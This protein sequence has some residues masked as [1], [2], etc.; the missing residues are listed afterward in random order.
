MDSDR[1]NETALLQLAR[2]V[3]REN[4]DA[5]DEHERWAVFRAAIDGGCSPSEILAAVTV[6][7]DVVGVAT[8]VILEMLERVPPGEM[9]AWT[10]VIP[11]GDARDLLE[12]RAAEVVVLRQVL[13][14][15]GR[16]VQDVSTWSDWL[17]RRVAV[18]CTDQAVLQVLTT[19]GRTKRVRGQAGE[20][21]RQCRRV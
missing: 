15:P 17:Q 9:A 21:L 20:R 16:G 3:G 8:S 10:Q 14:E 11:D 5:E 19:S 18:E 2:R 4:V 13:T 1:A 7:P 12:R 6:E